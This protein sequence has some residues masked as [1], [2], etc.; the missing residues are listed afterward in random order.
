MSLP[1]DSIPPPPRPDAAA[2]TTALVWDDRLAAY[3]FSDHHPMNPRRLALTAGLIRALGLVG[4]ER[5]PILPPRPATT[6]ELLLAHARE[7]VAAVEEL[8]RPGA[9]PAAGLPWGLGTED[10]PVVEGMDEIARLVVG[11]T[12]VAAEAVMEGR[13]RRA[14][15]PA[16][17]L[18]HAR[19]AEA[20]G[21]CIYNDL[22][23]AIRW[24]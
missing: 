12:L 6:D 9:D 10:T 7:F 22:A 20:A 16:G 11:G 4:D 5:R 15:N 2:P 24:M 1:A 18:H 13:A 23:V 14:F 19:R 17:G 3:G 8:S 21:F